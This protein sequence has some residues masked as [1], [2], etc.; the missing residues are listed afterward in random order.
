MSSVHPSTLHPP[1][2]PP[3]LPLIHL[4]IHPFHPMN[5]RKEGQLGH[6]ET[7][8]NQVSPLFPPK[9]VRWWASSSGSLF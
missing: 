1:T 2:H 4:S 3:I 5:E 6:L 7:P 8:S 9:S